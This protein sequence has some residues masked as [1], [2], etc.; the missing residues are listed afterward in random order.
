MVHF[1]AES[2]VDRSIPGAAPFVITNVLGTQTL[3]DA[4]LRHGVGRFLHVS[5]DEV[6]GSIERAPGPRTGRWRPNSPYS[7][8]KAGSDLIA[9]AYHRTHGLD[10]V[11]T[12]CSNN[13]GPV[14]VPGE[15]HPAVRDQPAGRKR[16]R[17]TATAATSATGCT[18]PTTAAAST[19]CCG[20]G[21][22]GEVYNIGGGTELTN[23]ELT[24]RLL[25]ACGAGWDMVEQVD[26]PQG[27]RPALLAG[28]HQDPRR[29]GLR[30]GVRLR[31][32]PGRDGRLVPGQP[33]LVGAAEGRPRQLTAT[34]WLVTG[35]G[36][37]L[38]R[39]LV[40][41]LALAGRDRHRA[42]PGRPRHHRRRPRWLPRGRGP[43]RG[44]QRGG[45]DRRGRRRGRRGRGDRGQRRRG[46][47]TWP[48]PAP[49]PARGCCTS[50]PTTSS[51]ATRSTPYPEDAPTAPVNAYGRSKLVG[52]QAVLELLPERGY[53]VRT[54]W[55]YGEHG[56][57]F[58]ATMLKLAAH[59]RHRRRGRRPARPAHLVRT[60]WPRGWSSSG[61]GALAGTAPAGVYHGTASGETTWY[62]LAEPCSPRLASTRS[63]SGRPPARPSSGRGPAR[64]Q[65]AGPRAAG[66]RP[67]SHRWRPWEAALR[68]A[69]TRPGFAAR[70]AALVAAS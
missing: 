1:A 50:P 13:Y 22:A 5:T 56:R 67:A 61:R 14:P 44:D 30:A 57:N 41:V 6:Y 10:V 60:R 34:R 24:G 70:V 25:E 49:T 62:G 4:A 36:G 2:H 51:P 3:L 16:C 47:R 43:R 8:S 59:P 32:R 69:L 54:A 12:R 66:P 7:A 46:R 42:G 27:P 38:G 68:E 33:R 55:L 53:V 17:S 28:H 20:K 65:R 23:R 52:E 48:R 9:L 29:A 40:T 19:W 11:V 63:G 37:M 45:L 35:A 31:R 39:D 58:V 15:G 21:R 18:W 26:R 64:L